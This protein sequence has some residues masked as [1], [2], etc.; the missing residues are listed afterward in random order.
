MTK[1]L[2]DELLMLKSE[3]EKIVKELKSQYEQQLKAANSSQDDSS[4]P[5]KQINS[6]KVN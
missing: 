6:L 5:G 2:N 1:K 4:S 3:H